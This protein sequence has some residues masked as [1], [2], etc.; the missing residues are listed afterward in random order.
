MGCIYLARCMVNGKGYVGKTTQLLE[1]RR[2]AHRRDAEKQSQFIFHRAI[3]KYGW[4][5]FEWSILTE[6]D[7]DEWL[8]LMEQKW[9][10]R[11]GTKTPNGYNMNDGGEGGVCPCE[12]VRE[13]KRQAM[14]GNT[15]SLGVHP[16]IESRNKMRE[17][18]ILYNQ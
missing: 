4:D 17:S 10:K 3:R 16:S 5:A 9:I 2:D 12:E 15:H 18:A 7:D 6:D 8:F 14:I 11:L 1:H 13:R